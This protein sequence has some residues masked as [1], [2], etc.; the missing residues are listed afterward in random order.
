MTFTEESVMP[1]PKGEGDHGTGP[2][3]P[4]RRTAKAAAYQRN[5]GRDAATQLGL[6]R[7]VWREWVVLDVQETRGKQ[8]SWCFN[9]NGIFRR[10][11]I[12]PPPKGAEDK[13]QGQG[14]EQLRQPTKAMLEEMLRHSWAW[15]G[16]CDESE[17]CWMCKRL[18]DTKKDW[19]HI[20]ICNIV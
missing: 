9:M 4:E 5:A 15:G 3:P 18:K 2:N 12:M 20:I 13:G 8:S 17:S 6:G 11:C 10:K 7:G 16:D 14:G 19:Y 1:A